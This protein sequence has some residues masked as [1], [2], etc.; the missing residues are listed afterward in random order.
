MEVTLSGIVTDVKFSHQINASAPMVVTL[1]GIVTDVKTLF[2][3]N[4]CISMAVTGLSL[5]EAGMSS[6][7]AL[8]V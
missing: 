8:P 4:A 1:S 7:V 3:R 5:M 2:S 6:V